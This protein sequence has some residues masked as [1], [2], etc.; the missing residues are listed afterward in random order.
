M[1]TPQDKIKAMASG[2]HERHLKALNFRKSANTWIRPTTWPQVIN[3]QLSRWNSVEEAQFTVNLGISIP[4]LHVASE[5]LPLKGALKEHDCDLRSRIG[6]LFPSKNDHW[7]KV[8][9]TTDPDELVEDVFA[10][11]NEFALPWFDRLTNFSSVAAEFR[12]RKSPFM[13]ALAFHLAG[14]S[15]SATESMSRAIE[16][17]NTHFL[18]KLRRIAAAQG[19]QIQEG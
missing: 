19:I 8:T 2:L 7:W 15:T 18:S 4:E 5:S 10:R 3:V 13:A 6:L 11:I 9:P 1:A 17:S 14:D 12:D 16:G